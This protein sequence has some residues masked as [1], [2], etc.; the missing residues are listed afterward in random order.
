MLVDD[1]VG[2]LQDGLP[3][4]GG[5]LAEQSLSLS[6]GAAL[7]VHQKPRGDV[8]MTLILD[9]ACGPPGSVPLAAA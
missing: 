2:D 4:V 8:D 5:D 6:C 9:V 3:L 1:A 7:R